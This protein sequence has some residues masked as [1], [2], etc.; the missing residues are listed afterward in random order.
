[1]R[2]CACGGSAQLD[3]LRID[4]YGI[5]TGDIYYFYKCEKC[6]HA[7]AGGKSCIT[8]MGNIIAEE[9]AKEIALK[10]WEKDITKD[11]ERERY[12]IIRKGERDGNGNQERRYI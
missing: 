4:P 12:Q 10:K 1:M 6:G 11:K 7:T 3:Q 5:H 2:K 9:K 8:A